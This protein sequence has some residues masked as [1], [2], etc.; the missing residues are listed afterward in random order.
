MNTDTAPRPKRRIKTRLLFLAV[1]VVIGAAIAQRWWWSRGHVSSDNAQIEGHIVPI[2]A[3]VG[4]Y[5]LKVPVTDNQTITEGGLLVELDSRDY[6]VKLAQAD[7]DYAQ[8]LAAAGS[9]GKPGQALA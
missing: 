7:A 4:G 5:V 3:R 8:A 2:A 1:L 9:G 6:A